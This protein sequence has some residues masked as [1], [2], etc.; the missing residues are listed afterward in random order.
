MP[1]PASIAT[2]TVVYVGKP[3]TSSRTIVAH[4][5]IRKYRLVTTQATAP[6]RARV[7]RNGN[8]GSLVDTNLSSPR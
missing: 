1:I 7:P 6:N 2:G 3:R 5:A 8:S 4:Q